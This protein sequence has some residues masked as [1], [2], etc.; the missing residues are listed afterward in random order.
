MSAFLSYVLEISIT[1][2]KCVVEGDDA[3]DTVVAG[4]NCGK[5]G[6]KQ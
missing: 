5:F 4:L 1:A 2:A 3:L 6:I